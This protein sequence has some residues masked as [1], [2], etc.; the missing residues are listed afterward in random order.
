ME[1]IPRGRPL[2]MKE[3][4]HL[5]GVSTKTFCRWVEQG[6][7]LPPRY[8]AGGKKVWYEGDYIHYRY[9]EANGAFAPEGPPKLADDDED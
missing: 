7:F 2:T 1:E 4:S 5:L 9:G 8:T 3:M 6:K